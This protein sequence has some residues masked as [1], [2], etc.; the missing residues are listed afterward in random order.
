M[1]VVNGGIIDSVGGVAINTYNGGNTTYFVRNNLISNITA[2]S[3]GANSGGNPCFYLDS[4]SIGNH[5]T[6]CEAISSA[7]GAFEIN[8]GSNKTSENTL[9]D[10]HFRLTASIGFLLNNA[11][12]SNHLIGCTS[13]YDG[14][15]G[16][17]ITGNNNSLV[18]CKVYN[19]GQNATTDAFKSAFYD[20]GTNTFFGDLSSIDDQLVHTIKY[21]LYFDT[22]STNCNVR[23]GRIIGQTDNRGLFIAVGAT[24][25]SIR[26][27][28]G[29]NPA[30]FTKIWS[31]PF[32]PPSGVYLP[33]GEPYPTRIYINNPGGMFAYDIKDVSG[34]E[35]GWSG[36]GIYLQGFHFDVNEVDKFT[37]YY[38]SGVAPTFN[39]Y[40]L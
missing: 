26:N 7:Y 16:F 4:G 31:A 5:I 11:P 33:T 8:D 38:P 30:G 37:V 34:T 40:G 1:N 3:C 10:C 29:I 36:S 23:D 17:A 24:G 20:N 15:E 12:Y 39:W 6:H 13:S 28:N 19:S 27:V 9:E 35:V 14:Y 2:T 22:S 32:V 25:T 18:G 21:A